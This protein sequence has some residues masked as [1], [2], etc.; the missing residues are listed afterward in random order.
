MAALLAPGDR[1]VFEA[2]V[3]AFELVTLFGAFV[4]LNVD[5]AADFAALDELALRS[6][7]EAADA[8]FLLV[9][10]FFVIF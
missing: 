6:T 10:S 3:L 1:S 9:T 7:V 5:P 4:W 2:A 8:A